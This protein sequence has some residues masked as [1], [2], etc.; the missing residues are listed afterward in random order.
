MP[1]LT[2]A[3]LAGTALVVALTATGC[4]QAAPQ[5]AAI[6]LDHGGCGTGWTRPHGGD[7]T[8]TVHNATT[9]SMEVQLVD[10]ATH[11]VYAEVEQLAPGTSRPMKVVLAP[12]TYAFT[13]FPD[14]GDAETGP[15]VIIKDG[16]AHGTAAVSP[17]GENDLAASVKAY[18]A[19]VTQGLATLA[20]DVTALRAALATGDRARAQAAWL[21][22]Q[23]AYARLGAAYDTFGALADAI[24]GIPAGDAQ[25]DGLRRIEYGLWHAEA[26]PATAK[27]ADRL[28]DDVATLRADFAKERTDPND[29]PLRSHEI[30]ENSLQS[31]LTGDADQGSGDG[32]ATISANL[33]GTAAVLDAIAPVLRP[34]YPGWAHVTA[35]LAAMKKLIDAQHRNGR[36]T[37]PAA[38][39]TA[40]RERLDGALGE[41]LEDL[42]PIAAIGEVRR[43]S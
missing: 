33:D 20:A 25:G 43:T 40:D 3:R 14:G 18:R 24:D 35:E 41:L 31:E 5:P 1:R 32:L 22:A 7:Q 23:M 34:R 8:L 26:L 16:P 10:P 11:G 37:A 6:E 15:A 12:G 42:A 19:H 39:P 27:V 9:V 4:T 28:A 29:L 17:V 13:C 36:W 21:T 30:L 38:L 2:G